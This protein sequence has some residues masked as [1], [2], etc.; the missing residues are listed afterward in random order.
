MSPRTQTVV[1][2]AIA[3]F[4]V[5]AEA[6]DW[7]GFRGPNGNGVTSDTGFPTKWSADENVKWKVALSE[8]SNGSPIVSN[9]CVFLASAEDDGK[10]RTLSCYDRADGSQKWAKTVAFGKETPT[11][12]QNPHGSTTPAADGKHVVVWHDSAGLYCY[13][14]EGKELWKRDLGEFEHMYGGGTSPVIHENRV[15][16]HSGPGKRVFVGAYDLGTGK[17]LWETEEKTEGDH[18]KRADGRDKGSWSTPVIA[19]VNGSEQ[20]I[21]TMTTR[22]NGYD[23]E[24]GELVW[25][26]GGLSGS[27]G[28]VVSS[29]PLVSGGVC[30]VMAGYRGPALAVKID[31][32]GDVTESKRIWYEKRNSESIG[33]G[34]FLGDHI[35][36]PNAGPGTIE[37]TD[38]KTGEKVWSER[39]GGNHWGSMVL[40]DG[41]LYVT[42]QR[43]GTYVF[44][45]NHEEYEEVSQNEFPETCNATPAFSDG[46]I[47]IRTYEHL[48]C[49]GK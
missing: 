43:G 3:A 1:M 27:R 17:T 2:I 31:G 9:G 8:P 40:A 45:A 10:K 23:L 49:I 22:V 12:R 34:I 26:C 36:R 44:K 48:Y 37:C 25:W 7:P 16:L 19:S 35:F 29:S 41:N 30:V 11:H 28:D 32:K 24:S 18:E 5:S 46:Q 14:F 39:A 21:C 6:A 38:A 4:C 42:N 20:V 13:D 15:I 33:T 47:F